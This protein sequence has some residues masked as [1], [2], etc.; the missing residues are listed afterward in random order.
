ML[1]QKRQSLFHRIDL[2]YT[3]AGAPLQSMS[4]E[5]LDKIQADIS[6]VDRK[7]AEADLEN[8]K[9]VGG[10]IK[11][12]IEMRIQTEK[13]TRATLAQQYMFAKYGIAHLGVPGQQAEAEPKK[14]RPTVPDKGAL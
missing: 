10:L 3:V 1:E 8:E 2:T 5:Q 6:E 9:Y 11:G 13:Q 7:I 4:Q 12:L 14:D